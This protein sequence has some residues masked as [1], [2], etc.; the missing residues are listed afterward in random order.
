MFALLLKDILTLKKSLRFYAAFL[1]IYSVI[2]VTTENAAFFLSFI[3]L[4]GMML[5]LYAMNIDV[6][7]HWNRYAAC[8]PMPRAALVMSK[9]LLALFG[10]LIAL[11]PAA[12]LMGLHATGLLPGFTLSWSEVSLM[13]AL[14]LF[15]LAFQMPFLF[16]LGPERGRFASLAIL[17][18]FCLGVPV[19]VMQDGIAAVHETV[20]EHLITNLVSLLETRQWLLP[21]A[22]AACSLVSA[23]ISWAIVARQEID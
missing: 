3:V 10:I 2:G 1:V 23:C 16:W 14:G 11:L 18:L 9:Y 7:C 15:I 22:G 12:V 5:P 20:A 6:A 17:L 19:L 13:V 8:L 4:L 21:A